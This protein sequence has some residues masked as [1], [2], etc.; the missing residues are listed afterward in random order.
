MDEFN[1]NCPRQPAWSLDCELAVVKD[2]G[3]DADAHDNEEI[4]H[5]L[6]LV[7]VSAERGSCCLEDFGRQSVDDEVGRKFSF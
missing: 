7:K 3:A 4:D 2:A 1:S 5:C 6:L